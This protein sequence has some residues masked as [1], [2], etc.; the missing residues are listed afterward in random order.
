V[1]ER[2]EFHQRLVAVMERLSLGE[3]SRR[4]A[5]KELAIGYATLKRLLDTQMQS[6]SPISEK[7]L[8]PVVAEYG[9]DRNPYAEVLY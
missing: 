8:L 2:P 3:I 4:Q 7:S 1:T 9:G 5:A 6:P